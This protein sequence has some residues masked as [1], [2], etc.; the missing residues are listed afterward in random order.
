[1][2]FPDI[3]DI[4]AEPPQRPWIVLADT[5]DVEAWIAN[6]NRSLQ[7]AIVNPK[8]QGYGICFHLHEG[9]EIFLH[10]GGEGDIVL[11]V[12]PEAAWVAPLLTAATGHPAPAGRIWQLPSEVLTQLIFGLNSLIGSSRL[13]LSHDFRIKKY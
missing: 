2:D 7:A 9:G 10:T 5:Y 8:L 11:D 4:P 6:Y 13:V 3:D 1:M 12:E